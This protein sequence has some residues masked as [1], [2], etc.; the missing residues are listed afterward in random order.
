[1]DATRWRDG[2]QVM[3]KKLFPEEGPHELRIT[4]NFSSPDVSRDTRNHCVPLLDVIEIPK[5]GQKLMVMPFLRPFN[6]PHFQ[7]FGEFMAFFTQ[8]CEVS[9]LECLTS[10]VNF[11]SLRTRASNSCINT[12]YCTQVRAI[13]CR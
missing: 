5:T 8:V 1:M 13:A 7:T 3:L 9:S 2:K 4:Q 6:N 10:P 11:D 12:K